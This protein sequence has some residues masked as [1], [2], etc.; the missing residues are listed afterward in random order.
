V[1]GDTTNRR[2]ACP[3]CGHQAGRLLYS[4]S[5]GE[6]AGAF[7]SAGGRDQRVELQRAIERIWGRE[8]CD[9][10]QCEECTF[11]FAAP[12]AAATPDFYARLYCTPAGYSES[13]WEF[14]RSLSAIE[15][16]LRSS[17]K[18][19][20]AAADIGAGTGAFASQLSRTLP[21]GS[22]LFCTEYSDCGIDLIRGR[23]IPCM[24]GGLMDIS[25]TEFDHAFDI[26]SLFQ[27]L[28]HLDD[29]D[30]V[31]HRLHALAAEKAHLFLAVPNGLQRAYFDTLGF[32]EDRPPVHVARWNRRSLLI[33]AEKHGWK[34][35]EDAIE[36]EKFHSKVRR[37]AAQFCLTDRGIIA[38]GTVRP[39]PLRRLLRGGLVFLFLLR[40]ARAVIGLSSECLGTSY[41][42]HLSR[43]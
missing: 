17:E 9:F 28:E 8:S 23:G 2:T 16:V 14:Q 22:R 3:V 31:F 4:I 1:T 33:V 38:L 21:A 24:Q 15:E 29:V 20:F 40:S 10:L 35:E 42:V 5:S 36:P 34:L 7:A 19:E 25:I 12:F 39:R 41:W 32:H 26:L 27:V 30:A 37:L 11:C 18:D 43:R 6:A 13:K